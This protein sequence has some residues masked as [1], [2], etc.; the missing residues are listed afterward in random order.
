M[1]VYLRIIFSILSA[2]CVGALIPIG[3]ALGLPWALACLLGAGLFFLLMLMCKQSQE[4]KEQLFAE[5]SSESSTD[6]SK[7]GS[8]AASTENENELLEGNSTKTTILEQKNAE[9]DE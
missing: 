3:A 5:G 1:L 4:Q 8:K 7:D 9:K 2:V 6:S